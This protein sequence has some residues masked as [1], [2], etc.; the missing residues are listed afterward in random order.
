M[1]ALR[2]DRHLALR[3]VTAQTG[4]NFE[5]MQ[6][7]AARLPVPRVL[8][9]VGMGAARSVAD[10]QVQ[11]RIATT[12]GGP[13]LAIAKALDFC[14]IDSAQLFRAEGISLT[15]TNDPMLRL[16]TDTMRRLYGACVAATNDPYFGLTVARFIHISNLHA[17][18]F[19]LAAS[20][21]LYDFCLRLERYFRVLTEAAAISLI[22]AD[23][24]VI[25]RFDHLGD[26]CAE[27]EDAFFGFVVL[28]M[29]QLSSAR[30]NPL[31]VAFH[32]ATPVKGTAPFASMFRAPLTFGEAQSR[33]VFCKAEMI[34]PLAGSCT[35]LAQVHDN[36]ALKYLSQLDRNDVITRVKS[37]IIELLPNGECS[38][39]LVAKT[40]CM[41]PTT[42]QSKLAKRETTFHDLLDGTRLELARNYMQES[43]LSITDMTFMLG[44]TDT[45]NFSRA[46]K[47]WTGQSPTEF[48]AAL[49]A[50]ALTAAA[51]SS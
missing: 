14:G 10:M 3:P 36:I 29:R 8:K 2:C 4:G 47:R 24:E 51:P 44:F 49:H 23:G 27:A 22:E 46:F 37:A 43:A 40:M 45:S 19:A 48:R 5:Q 32:H 13:V 15:L 34:G 7:I 33:L 21:T 42:L 20:S 35:E 41:S 1:L 30:F 18:G 12:I 6:V 16:S 9:R 50:P 28:A 38:R 11:E 26:T 25:L 17:L 31:R 39:E